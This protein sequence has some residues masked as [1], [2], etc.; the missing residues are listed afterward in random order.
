MLGDKYRIIPRLFDPFLIEKSH[1]FL[2]KSIGCFG[3][4]VLAFF[5][6]YLNISGQWNRRFTP[7]LSRCKRA[8][9]GL[10][11][12]RHRAGRLPQTCSLTKCL[13]GILNA[14]GLTQAAGFFVASLSL[15]KFFGENLS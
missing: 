10:W 4:I 14:R 7:R 13:A 3:L 9:V 8:Y 5:L 15:E 6:R 1:N 2:K 11:R 12:K